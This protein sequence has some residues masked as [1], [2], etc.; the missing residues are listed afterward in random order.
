MRAVG[1]AQA[2]PGDPP[3]AD[4]G[5]A[6]GASVPA[7]PRAVTVA[8]T[9]PDYRIAVYDG[10]TD[11]GSSDD[12]R[13]RF[14]TSP[15]LDANEELAV[16][17][18]GGIR[19]ARASGGGNC[20]AALDSFEG[21]TYKDA[22][23]KRVYWQVYRPCNGCTPQDEKGAVRSFFVRP[24]RISAKLDAPARVYGGYPALV[25]VANK[26]DVGLA[27]ISL[28][29]RRGKGWR[30]FATHGQVTGRTELVGTLAT[31]RRTLRAVLATRSF[32][33]VLA[34]RTLT[35]RSPRG[36]RQISGHD[37]GRYAARS[38]SDRRRATLS[39]RITNHG[40]VLRGFKASVV[41]FCFGPTLGDNH[42]SVNFALLGPTR[43][44]PDG[45]VTGHLAT[46]GQR[47]ELKLTGRVHD[48]R[49]R[50]RIDARFSTCSGVR[51]LDADRR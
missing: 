29:Y 49:F 41:T 10:Y 40:T 24:N 42:I 28:Q 18:F 11:F 34:T 21:G 26:A 4:L 38:A 47:S 19:S 35:V 3:I 30:T 9:W 44:A 39:F 7:G 16:S 15:A 25:S 31:G 51:K 22:I 12:Y 1:V 45:S 48:R 6:D 50:G 43:I 23:G 32:S 5:P 14:S 17:A 2:L 20:T 36:R 27:T 33:Q 13:A 8:F 37:D 46:R